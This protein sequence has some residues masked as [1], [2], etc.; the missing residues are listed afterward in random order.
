[1]N[2]SS[3]KRKFTELLAA[4]AAVL[5][6]LRRLALLGLLLGHAVLDHHAHCTARATGHLDA[7]GFHLLALRIGHGRHRRHAGTAHLGGDFPQTRLHGAGGGGQ[8]DTGE[9]NE[10]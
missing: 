7:H 8:A 1:M 2:I 3:F 9:E 6:G 5:F 4:L 10:E